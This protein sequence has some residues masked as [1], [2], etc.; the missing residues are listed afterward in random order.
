MKIR[1]VIATLML[2]TLTACDAS[3]AQVDKLTPEQAASILKD[4]RERAF[5]NA[6]PVPNAYTF[7]E[8][9]HLQNGFSQIRFQFQF[10]FNTM[11]E[12][13]DAIPAFVREK[14]TQYS[15]GGRANA[16]ATSNTQYHFVGVRGVMPPVV[17]TH[18]CSR[19]DPWAPGQ[20]IEEA[21]F[22]KAEEP[23]WP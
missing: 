12:C 8:Y 18:T 19:I 7:V 20:V 23:V 15:S 3:T 1:T 16:T 6:G 10:A 2:F 21:A 13:R 11:Q 4:A 14:L 17:F 22:V 9:A 5:K